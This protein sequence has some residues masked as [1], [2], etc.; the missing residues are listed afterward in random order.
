M[1]AEIDACHYPTEEFLETIRAVTTRS[2]ARDLLFNVIVDA[3]D[4]T[5][6]GRARVYP[7]TDFLD[8]EVMS[9]EIVTGGW[10]GV[11]SIV[12]AMVGGPMG[13]A[14][15]IFGSWLVE[16]RRGGLWRFEITKED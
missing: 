5:G 7:S 14:R 15:I 2:E 12:D 4:E 3:I 11:E 13:P 1:N 6:Y 8:H 9:V 10:S 16:W